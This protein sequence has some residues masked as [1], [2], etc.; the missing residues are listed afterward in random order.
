LSDN[1]EANPT[2]SSPKKSTILREKGRGIATIVRPEKIITK[3]PTED[4][5]RKYLIVFVNY[6]NLNKFFLF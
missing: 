2:T 1:D 4:P 5:L 6:K 3:D